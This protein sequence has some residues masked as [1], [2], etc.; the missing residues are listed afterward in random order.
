MMKK[1]LALLF[2]ALTLFSCGKEESYKVGIPAISGMELYIYGGKNS[3]VYLGKLDAS[4]FDTESIWNQFGTYGNRFNTKSLWNS[5]GDYGN[6]MSS[7][8]PFN[9]YAN[10]PP[11]L[12]DKRGNFKGY[13]TID[14]NKVDRANSKVADVIC[15][16]YK[17][18]REDVSGWYDKIFN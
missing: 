7:Y 5:Y 11:A 2:A 4:K 18:I 3:D 6:D 8:S 1:V 15:D 17:E 13:F 12:Y 14:R 9:K 10:W 16:H